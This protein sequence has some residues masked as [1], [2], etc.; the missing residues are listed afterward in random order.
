MAQ[1]L[2]YPCWRLSLYTRTCPRLVKGVPPVT[3]ARVRD[4]SHPGKKDDYQYDIGDFFLILFLY[5]MLRGQLLYFRAQ[6][7]C[8]TLLYQLYRSISSVKE[9]FAMVRFDMVDPVILGPVQHFHSM[10]S[11]L[12]KRRRFPFSGSRDQH[13]DQRNQQNGSRKEGRDQDRFILYGVRKVPRARLPFV[14]VRCP[15]TSMR[16]VLIP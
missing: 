14:A 1:I 13:P 7:T 8:N 3:E 5:N 4:Q 9:L 10:P 16:C 15:R 12:L 11:P 6:N 2:L